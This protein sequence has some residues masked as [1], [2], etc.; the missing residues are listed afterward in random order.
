MGHGERRL[1]LGAARPQYDVEID[2]PRP[3][4]PA[5]PPAEAAL[6]GFSRR[7]RAG[8]SSSL[9][10]GT[11]ALAS[12]VSRAK[13]RRVQDRETVVTPPNAAIAAAISRAGLP[14][15]P[16]LGSIRS[17]WHSLSSPCR[18]A[19][20][21]GMLQPSRD[22]PLCP[23]L[24]ALR[25]HAR[26]TSRLV[27]CAGARAGR[28]RRADRDRGPCASASTVPT[29]PAASLPATIPARCCSRRWRSS[30]WP[31]AASPGAW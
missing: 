12:G 13:R 2:H 21:A 7:S 27:E 4:V 6:D 26:R 11:T 28:S 9:S 3:P 20:R 31:R 25:A 19:Y 18:A 29:A 16:H 15:R 10:I 24:V 30:G 1:A 8:G 23:R 22:Y 5:A 17:R 14:W